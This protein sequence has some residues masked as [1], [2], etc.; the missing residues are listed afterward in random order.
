M[1][2]R[3]KW[4]RSPSFDPVPFFEDQIVRDAFCDPSKVR[5][6][7]SSWVHKRR[8]KVHCS[9]TELLALATSW[10]SKGACKFFRF[11]EVDLDECVGLFAVPK[12]DQYDRLILNPQVANS[13]MQSFSHYTKDLAPGSL[14]WLKEGQPMRI[15][16][17][18]LAEM[19]YT[20]KVL[21]AR[22][23]RNS[24]GCVFQAHELSS[25]NC[26][27]GN[28][29]LSMHWPWGTHGR[30]SLP[31]KAITMCCAVWLAACLNISELHIAKLMVVD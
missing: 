17:D 16:A 27:D 26:Y 14:I 19:Y 31:S 15:S 13:R 29:M 4:E 2:S 30:L 8:A 22:A 24:V 1:A 11:D 12:D 28:Q 21:E 23:K 3:I 10:D 7:P 9:K 25:L 18:D 5:S 6:H 20:V